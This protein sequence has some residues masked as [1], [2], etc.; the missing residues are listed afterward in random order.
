MNA[1]VA[2]VAAAFAVPLVAPQ[3]LQPAQTIC[4]V[5]LLL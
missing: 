2:V 5:V 1:A 3:P 4:S